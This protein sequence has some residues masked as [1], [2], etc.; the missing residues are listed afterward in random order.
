ME[1][2]SRSVSKSQAVVAPTA[3]VP[4]GEHATFGGLQFSRSYDC[5]VSV[6]YPVSF[7]LSSLV[8]RGIAFTKTYPLLQTSTELQVSPRPKVKISLWDAISMTETGLILSPSWPQMTTYFPS[9]VTEVS[10]PALEIVIAVVIAWIAW[11]IQ[12]NDCYSELLSMT[13][14]TLS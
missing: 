13:K 9:G 14:P 1:K 8:L 2:D 10:S 12:V 11:I 4:S 6:R 3:K 5:P 7:I